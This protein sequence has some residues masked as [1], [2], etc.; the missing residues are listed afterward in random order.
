MFGELFGL[1]QRTILWLS[2]RPNRLRMRGARIEVVAVVLTREPVPS[3][4]LG[5]SRYNTW[6]LPQEGVN[7]K[8]TFEKA[9][10]RCLRVECGLN[11]P[12]GSDEREREFF[13]RS[14]QYKGML[15]QPKERW[16][17]RLVA[18]DCSGTP[19]ESVKMWRKAYWVGIVLVRSQDRA[20]PKP[21]GNEMIE[22]RWCELEEA[23]RLIR[24]SNRA[25]KCA[26]LTEAI[27]AGARQL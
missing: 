20:S 16:G 1:V 23:E 18:D 13:V 4:L 19:L 9:L 21:D 25:E 12:V 11:V 5:R 2:N 24:D 22:L 10:Y 15:D 27:K 8:E 14:I 7:L 6:I 3:V 26:L 17:E